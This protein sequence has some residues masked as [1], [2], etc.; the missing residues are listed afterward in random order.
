MSEAMQRTNKPGHGDR[1]NERT[2]ASR[3]HA[4]LGAEARLLLA[5]AEWTDGAPTDRVRGHA[6]S[7]GDWTAAI[8]MAGENRIVPQMHRALE[9]AGW[10]HVPEENRRRLDVLQRASALHGLRLFRELVEL[11]RLMAD[12]GVDA[13]AYKGPV[14][15]TSLYGNLSHRQTW[16]LDLLVKPEDL[17][18]G[19]AV[20][21][22]RGY[23]PENE[24][25]LAPAEWLLDRDCECN[26][27]H[28]SG[29]HVEL[30]WQVLPTRHARS[31]RD[32]RIWRNVA[33]WGE[34][35]T[36]LRTIEPRM[37]FLVLC[38]HGGEK[39]QWARMRWIVDL[40]RFVRTYP[41][42]DWAWIADQAESMELTR[43][44]CLGL[45]LAEALLGAPIPETWRPLVAARPPVADLA[46]LARG[47]LFRRDMGLPGY[48]EWLSYVND[49]ASR[50]R[51]DLAPMHGGI[52]RLR[53]F[54][55]VMTPEWQDRNRL[56]AL[57]GLLGFLPYCVRL[58]RLLGRHKTADL[59]KRTA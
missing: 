44:V 37:L 31:F 53:Y 12:R 42:I 18:R 48:R 4:G 14:L 6:E 28:P 40:A 39:H 26:F 56:P 45:Y 33:E 15:A 54:R 59:I 30:H 16:D 27:D 10:P 43:T 17:D 5:C 50:S 29:I 13:I 49:H 55:A 25:A 51:E 11:T 7:V 2:A 19:R 47:R 38:L 57:P 22:E 1:A 21:L 46:G 23:R 41:D 24:L 8:E 3:R 9:A 35:G 32:D 34:N 36:R 58:L 20:V 52:S